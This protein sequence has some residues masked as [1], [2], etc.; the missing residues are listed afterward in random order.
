MIF[1]IGGTGLVG[2]AFLRY[3][4]KN[5]LNFKLITRKN[6]INFYNKSCDILIDCNGNGSKRLGSLDPFFDFNASVNSVAENLMKIKFKKYI[7]ISSVFTYSNLVN[8]NFTKENIKTNYETLIP[9]GFNKLIAEL[10][11]KKY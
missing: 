10:Y 7:Y 9:Y 1:L 2:S 6:K 5:K 4:K 11:V 3:L 8:K